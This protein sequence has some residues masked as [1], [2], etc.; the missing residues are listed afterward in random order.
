[1]DASNDPIAD[2]PPPPRH[3]KF[4]DVILVIP[5]YKEELVI[6]SIVLKAR[7]F[8]ER[9]I[10]VDDGSMDR[11]S[12]VATYAGANVLAG[13]LPIISEGR[14]PWEVPVL[15]LSCQSHDRN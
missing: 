2:L 15:F 6:G 8:V 12:E 13:T 5:A 1:M 10:V 3:E 9:V 14:G 4:K 7:Q 11:T